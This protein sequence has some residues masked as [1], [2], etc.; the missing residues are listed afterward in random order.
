MYAPAEVLVVLCSSPVARLV[1]TTEAPG[2]QQIVT[3]VG[4]I[5]TR[6]K[7]RRTQMSSYDVGASS[8]LRDRALARVCI[9]LHQLDI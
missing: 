1:A 5:S 6:D 9:A 2:L 8:V 3:A 7:S 4:G